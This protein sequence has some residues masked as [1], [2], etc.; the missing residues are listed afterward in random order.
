M[1]TT[2]KDLKSLFLTILLGPPIISVFVMV[3]MLCT[4]VLVSFYDA[5]F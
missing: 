3:V 5:I 1:M 2:N 4:K